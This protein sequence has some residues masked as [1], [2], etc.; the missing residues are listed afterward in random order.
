M[1]QNLIRKE[2][3]VECD[4]IFATPAMAAKLLSFRNI[5][6]DRMPTL[7]NGNPYSCDFVLLYYYVQINRLLP[8]T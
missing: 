7:M 8:Q 1:N 6:G 4:F 5:V 3:I 2:D